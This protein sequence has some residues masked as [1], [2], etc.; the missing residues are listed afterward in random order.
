MFQFLP[1][2]H[3]DNRGYFYESFSVSEI[4]DFQVAQMNVSFSKQGTIRGI[5]YAKN[6]P[7]QEKYVQC[8]EGEILDVVVD[9]RAN[10]GTFGKWVSLTISA[11][12]SNAVYIPNGFG[13][14]FQVVSETAKVVYLCSTLYNPSNEFSINPF[15]SNL[16]IHWPIRDAIISDKDANAPLLNNYVPLEPT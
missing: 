10:S 15:D 16:A 14:A 7:G 4:A 8:L 3:S 2:I 6:P 13:H 5:H 1:D 9:L 12:M 11:S